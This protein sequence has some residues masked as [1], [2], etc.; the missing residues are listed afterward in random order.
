MISTKGRY[1]LRVMLD[2]AEHNSDD[3]IPLNEIAQRQGI[4]I[5][6]LEIILKSLVKEKLLKGRRG[7]GGGYKLTRPPE[8]YSVGE[9]LELTEGSLAIVACLQKGADPCERRSICRTVAMWNR[10]SQ[11]VSDF[12]YGISLA[13]MLKEARDA[14]LYQIEPLNAQK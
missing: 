5:K 2:M 6:Y 3:F 9:I 14:N 13:D 12:F 11:M 7:K 1:A 8:E 10:F 4:S